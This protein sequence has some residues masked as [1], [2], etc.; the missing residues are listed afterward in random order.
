MTLAP[1]NPE[2]PLVA[3]AE[4]PTR[5]INTVADIAMVGTVGGAA[6]ANAW[7]LTGIVENVEPLDPTPS[8]AIFTVLSTLAIGA[9]FAMSA[10]TR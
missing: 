7:I 6:G 5:T 3:T 8:K 10:R 1:K 2:Q 4:T 9:A